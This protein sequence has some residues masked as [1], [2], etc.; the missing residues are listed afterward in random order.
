MFVECVHDVVI[1]MMAYHRVVKVIL[2]HLETSEWKLL[3]NVLTPSQ[4][5]RASVQS[6]NSLTIQKRTS[7]GL[8]RCSCASCVQ[9]CIFSLNKWDRSLVMHRLSF[10][11]HF[12]EVWEHCPN[13]IFL[14]Y[15]THHSIDFSYFT[16]VLWY[17]VFYF[18]LSVW[19][20]NF[21][22]FGRSLSV[23]SEPRT[24]FKGGMSCVFMKAP[25]VKLII[26][27]HLKHKLFIVCFFFLF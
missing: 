17:C 21:L 14:A 19:C 9:C 7:C 20:K 13:W 6:L 1:D 3:S 24:N 27:L 26:T 22:Y 10:I 23:L 16:L 4:E 11:T 2:K 12:L 8:F 18:V 15:W 25:L 5:K